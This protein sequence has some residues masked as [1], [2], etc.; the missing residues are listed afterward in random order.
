M[1]AFSKPWMVRT[2]SILHVVRQAGRDAVRIHLVGVEPFGLDEDLVRGL[3]GEPDYLV[4]DARAVA[5]AHA[6]DLAG[7]HRRAIGGGADDLVRALGGRRDVAG[8]L[9]ADDRSRGRDS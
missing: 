6:F 7:E 2:N 9:R 1:C 4:L 8:Q 3:V 5:R